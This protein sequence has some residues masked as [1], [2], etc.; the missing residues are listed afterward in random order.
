MSDRSTGDIDRCGAFPYPGSKG[1]LADWIIDHIP[2]HQCYVEPF[3]GSAAVLLQKPKSTVEILND[4]DGDIVHFYKVLRDREE[5][6]VEWLKQTPFSRDLHRK[7]SHQYYA[8]YRPDDDLERAG[9]WF[10]LRNTQ[11]AQ[12]YTCFSGFR[13][14]Q[15]RN[16]ASVYQNRTDRLHAVADRLRHV[17]V[18][19]RDYVDLVDRTDAEDTCFYFDPPYVDVGDDIYSH[20][21]AFDHDRFVDVLEDTEANWIVSYTDLPSSLNDD[22]YVVEQSARGTMR[23]GQGG[24]EQENTERLVMNFDPSREPSF[25]DQS[26]TQRTLVQTDGGQN[27]RSVDTETDQQGGGKA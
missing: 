8:G 22:Y 24:W 14:C 3:G 6:L 17:Q 7:Y 23:A 21:E 26:T 11:F 9:R 13:L 25:V 12:K 16:H 1:R 4:R 10:Y 2:D 20:E 5:E 15:P 27:N 18:A 19:N